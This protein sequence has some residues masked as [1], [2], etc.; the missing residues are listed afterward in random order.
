MK[1]IFALFLTIVTFTLIML[2]SASGFTLIDY[3]DKATLSDP[4]SIAF[5]FSPQ[6]IKR[7]PPPGPCTPDEVCLL[8]FIVVEI[9]SS[10]WLN[11]ENES[12]TLPKTLG[13]I[14][15]TLKIDIMS[16]DKIWVTS[17]FAL[18]LK[19]LP[20][21]TQAKMSLASLTY[22][23]RPKLSSLKKGILSYELV[24]SVLTKK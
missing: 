17:N 24:S 20:K 22:K 5:Y 11:L 21:Y 12:K 1:K 15:M 10:N 23:F 19:S 4:S 13:K 18:N 2:A 7:P 14:Q 8:A 6:Y 9:P 16:T 3:Q